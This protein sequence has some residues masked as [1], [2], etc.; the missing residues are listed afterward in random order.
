MH[1]EYTC[2]VEKK[3]EEKVFRKSKYD[4]HFNNNLER[5]HKEF[6]KCKETFNLNSPKKSQAVS[7]NFTKNK[8]SNNLPI[9]NKT[10]DDFIFS[11]SPGKKTKTLES[12]K[13]KY[14]SGKDNFENSNF[15]KNHNEIF[16]SQ[17][18][19]INKEKESNSKNSY[20][21]RNVKDFSK[22]NKIIDD[23]D[24]NDI[25]SDCLEEKI[26]NVKNIKIKN[27]KIP[28]IKK[29]E[30]NS[31]ILYDSDHE[32]ENDLLKSILEQ[33]KSEK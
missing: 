5:L 1:L 18:S 2:Q 16:F 31:K 32:I 15:N 25:P 13:S 20:D 12:K 3:K 26:S 29:K 21:L 7:N 28:F 23:D 19:L 33:S 24:S 11:D 17:T 9:K 10:I 27:D 4:D 8:F 6:T 14:D 22:K 30:N